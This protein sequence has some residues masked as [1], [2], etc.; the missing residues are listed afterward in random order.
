MS[1]KSRRASMIVA[2]DAP[3]LSRHAALAACSIRSPDQSTANDI[4]YPRR[5]RPQQHVTRPGMRRLLAS[6]IDD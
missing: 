5:T 4:E 3:N 1:G 2:S 6:E